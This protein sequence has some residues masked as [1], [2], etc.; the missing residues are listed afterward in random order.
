M[1]DVLNRVQ[2]NEGEKGHTEWLGEATGKMLH[3][4]KHI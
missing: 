4:D 2:D 1:Q 3:P